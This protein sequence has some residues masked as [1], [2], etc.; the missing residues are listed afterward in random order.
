MVSTRNVFSFL[1]LSYSKH[2]FSMKVKNLVIW[3]TLSVC[4]LC[5]C[6]KDELDQK[7]IEE[8][9]NLAEYI[10]TN[11]GDLAIDLGGGAFLVKTQENT[12]GAVVEAGNYILWNWKQTNHETDELE[13][14]SD[15]SNTKFSGS[16]VFGG[17]EITLV[18]SF[19]VDEGLKQMK[20]GEK[21]DMYIPSRWLYCDFQSRK[22][23]V[24]I[25]N[26]I[27][28]L[29]PYQE[30]LMSEY[31]KRKYRGAL[32]DTI[33][34]VSSIDNTEYNVMYHICDEGTGDA[35]TDGMNISAKTSISYLIRLSRESD[36][37]PYKV[38]QEDIKWNTNKTNFPTLTKTNCVGEIL[39]KIKKG[40]KVEVVMSSKLFWED[41]NLPTNI[42]D[43]YF[44]PQWSVVIFTIT[45]K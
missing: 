21:G 12:E 29:S 41:K 20:K 34:A 37:H 35:I 40:G 23:S 43:Q 1:R 10:K 19:K 26:V 5:A 33:K 44:I 32:A 30:A 28:D 7:F 31:I 9:K 36:I 25:V 27:K 14:T 39:K 16:Y 24:E 15:L 8:E 6:S 4:A 17:P 42:Y 11:Y 3:F 22:V 2:R 38:D 13:Y 18:K 45:V